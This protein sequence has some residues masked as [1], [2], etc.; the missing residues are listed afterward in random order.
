MSAEHPA[1]SSWRWFLLGALSGQLLFALSQHFLVKHGL[2]LNWPVVAA[3]VAAIG[4]LLAYE[5]GR[6]LAR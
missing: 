4:L 6:R 5:I 3:L 2:D 1:A